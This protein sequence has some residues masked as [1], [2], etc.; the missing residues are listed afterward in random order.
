M[1]DRDFYL[2][3]STEQQEAN[4]QN[5]TAISSVEI[6]DLIQSRWSPRAFDSGKNVSHDDLTA[7]LEAARWAPSCFNEQP[8]R[9]IV[10]VK[11]KDESSWQNALACLADKNKQWAKNAPIL[12]LAAAME[13]FSHNGKPNRWAIYDTGAASV[14]LCLQATALGLVVHQMGGFD[15]EKTREL[16]KL[17]EDCTPMSMMAVG[18]Q[19][20]IDVLDYDFKTAELAERNR[21]PLSQH[22]YYGQWG[23]ANNNRLST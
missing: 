6:H 10:C 17:P 21:A 13:N 7:L 22:F 16:F 18:Y 9:Y 2:F 3:L 15:A 11:T 4:M 20:D 1:I 23:S 8:W 19:A 5:K 14:S 12:I